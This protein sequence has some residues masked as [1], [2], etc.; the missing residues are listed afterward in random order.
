MQTQIVCAMDWK[1]VLK[2]YIFGPYL[3]VPLSQMELRYV[4]LT[5]SKNNKNIQ[6]LNI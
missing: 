6:F 2:N 3:I 1:I 4:K 5:F